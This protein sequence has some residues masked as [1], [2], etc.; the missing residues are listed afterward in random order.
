MTIID[1]VTFFSPALF[2]FVS[3]QGIFYAYL[4]STSPVY[5][6]KSICNSLG[7]KLILCFFYMV[8]VEYLFWVPIQIFLIFMLELVVLCASHG[9]QVFLHL[10]MW[11]FA[12]VL[13]IYKIL[14][15]L[16][17]NVFSYQLDL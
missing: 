13:V 9:F 6:V 12:D 10:V 2:S 5:F 17:M 3:F 16:N 8:C 15:M 7:T 1:G 4:C 11:S 14:V